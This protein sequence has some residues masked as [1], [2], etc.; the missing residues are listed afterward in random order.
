MSAAIAAAGLGAELGVGGVCESRLARAGVQTITHHSSAANDSR[1]RVRMLAMRPD[2][3]LEGAVDEE[4]ALCSMQ[5]GQ[6][7]RA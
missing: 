6:G 7:E 1:G 2:P 3:R 5:T 4:L